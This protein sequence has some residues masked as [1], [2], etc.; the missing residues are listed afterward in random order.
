MP[1]VSVII[2]THNRNGFLQSAIESVLNQTFQAFEI[3]VVDDASIDDVQSIV[4]GF[5]DRRIK[6]IR[7][8]INK[9]EAGARNTGIM[10]S[11]GEFIAFLDDD[12]IWFPDKLELQ[13]NVLENSHTHVGGIYSGFIAMECD[14][15]ISHTWIPTSKGD[16]YQDLLVKNTIGTPSTL[17][18]KRACIETAGVFDENLFYNVDHDFYLRIAKHFH[19]EYIAKPLVQYNIHE[20]R[21]SN[22]PEVV[23]KGF[24]AMSRKYQGELGK[25]R[26]GR[27]YL[28]RGFLS[29]GVGFC[30][31]GDKTKGFEAIMKSIRLYPFEPRAY[32]NLGLSLLGTSNFI[33]I[34]KFKNILVN[35]F[36]KNNQILKLP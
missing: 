18:I 16:I 6:Y 32:F 14:K 25:Y 2:P 29:V 8:E 5:H 4:Q 15:Q 3:I 9:G 26:K 22:N 13:M 35:L 19:F 24:E 36:K 17:L 20:N 33:K 28:A 11:K 1:I 10:H 12:D 7:H 34:K 23:A 21:L 31:K 30:Y 27:K